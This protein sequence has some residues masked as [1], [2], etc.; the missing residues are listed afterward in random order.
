MLNSKYLQLLHVEMVA[1]CISCSTHIVPLSSRCTVLVK[2][3]PQ[4]LNREK[5]S[6]KRSLCID[7]FSIAGIA[8]NGKWYRVHLKTGSPYLWQCFTVKLCNKFLWYLQVFKRKIKTLVSCIY[9]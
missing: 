8:S 1:F 5:C 2:K 3:Q 6:L 7:T 4:T 9:Y